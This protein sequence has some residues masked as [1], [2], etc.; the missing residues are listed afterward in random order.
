SVS[1]PA[2][3]FVGTG[4]TK[5]YPGQPPGD[6]SSGPE[7]YTRPTSLSSPG[8]ARR[9][10][11][12][13]SVAQPEATPAPDMLEVGARTGTVEVDPELEGVEVDDDLDFDDLAAPP[14]AKPAAKSAAKPAA[15]KV[16]GA[17]GGVR[18]SPEG[19]TIAGKA[20]AKQPF[21]A[22]KPRLLDDDDDD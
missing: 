6:E 12:K 4:D 2:V 9:S 19:S 17:R 16:G 5:H 3:G 15:A 13:R 14:A 21:G 7:G 10:S 20:S 18:A 11:Q 1:H 8:S 22:V